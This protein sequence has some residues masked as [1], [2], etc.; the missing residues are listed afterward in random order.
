MTYPPVAV[1]DADLPTGLAVTRSLG[2]AGVP[3]TVYGDSRTA[4]ARHSRFAAAFCECPH[5]GD[6]DLFV[7]WLTDEL[8]AGRITLIAPTSDSVMFHTA[9]AVDRLRSP[10]D[11][12]HPRPQAIFDCLLKQQFARAL[13]S[14]GFPT[15]A[16]AIPTSISDAI[17]FAEKV[18]YPLV[19]KPRTHVGAGVH[20]G[21]VYETESDLRSGFAPYEIGDGHESALAHD[22]DLQWPLLQE[23]IGVE[24][25]EVVS[26]SGCLSPEGDVLAVGHSRKERLWPPQLGIGTL[27]VALESHPFTDHVLDATRAILGSGIF[28]FE[29]LYHPETGDYWAIDLNPRAFGQMTLDIARGNDLPALW[30]EAVTGE[31]LQQPGPRS[32][33]PDRWQLGVPLLTDLSIEIASGPDRRIRLN[34]LRHSLG[35]SSVGAVADWADPIPALA[36]SRSFLRHPGGLVRPYLA[37]SWPQRFGADSRTR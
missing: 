23:F 7:D 13:D 2:R 3:V 6:S 1:F 19:S 16:T 20:R 9:C 30:Y 33:V 35:R 8:T 27:F 11:V 29:V 17:E 18:G 15:P 24:S 32:P 34:E 25:L 37:R 5:L 28:E 21:D 4:V 10:V 14:Y 31:R 36:F 22:P 26:V 12:G